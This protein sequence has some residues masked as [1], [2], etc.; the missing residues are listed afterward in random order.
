M[1][2]KGFN[3]SKAYESSFLNEIELFRYKFKR[4]KINMLYMLKTVKFQL[5]NHCKTVPPGED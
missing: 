2:S 3:Y 1:R 5:H 4:K